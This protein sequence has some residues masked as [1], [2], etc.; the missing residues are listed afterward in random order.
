MPSPSTDQQLQARA[1]RVAHLFGP[2]VSWL[3]NGTPAS[4]KN[5]V[6]AIF[7]NFL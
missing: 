2:I 7:V 6:L 5:K 3:N 4:L 1:L